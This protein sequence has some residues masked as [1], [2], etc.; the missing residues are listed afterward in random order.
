MDYGM[1]AEATASGR[2][3]FTIWPTA[4]GD[5]V[6]DALVKHERRFPPGSGRVRVCSEMPLALSN[7]RPE[8]RYAYKQAA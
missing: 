8:K 5:D 1:L 6:V 4:P 7:R 3:V 2:A